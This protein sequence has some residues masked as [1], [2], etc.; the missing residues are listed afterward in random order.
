MSFGRK[1]SILYDNNFIVGAGVQNM[2][3]FTDFI[4]EYKYFVQMYVLPLMGLPNISIGIKT[5]KKNFKFLAPQR[6]FMTKFPI[7]YILLILKKYC[8]I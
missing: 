4:S 8:S 6:S 1:S 3:E 5:V 7:E 2:R